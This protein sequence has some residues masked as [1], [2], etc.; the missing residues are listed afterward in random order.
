MPS[1]ETPDQ[2]THR[3]AAIRALSRLSTALPSPELLSKDSGGIVIAATVAR[4][5]TVL[6]DPEEVACLNTAIQEYELATG[7]LLELQN[8]PPVPNVPPMPVLQPRVAE[9]PNV[10]SFRIHAADIQLTFNHDW[11]PAQLSIDDWFDTLGVELVA[12]FQT[13]ALNET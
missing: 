8:V 3:R 4:L 1:V 11:V 12:D 7:R 13:W 9:V 6:Q 2:R 5:R 10:A